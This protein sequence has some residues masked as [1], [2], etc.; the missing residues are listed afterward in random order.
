[1]RRHLAPALG[2]I[3]AANIV[4]TAGLAVGLEAGLLVL[5][6]GDPGEISWGAEIAQALASKSINNG[7]VWL[8]WLVP[9]GAALSLSVVGFAL[10][11]VALEPRS[12]PRWNRAQ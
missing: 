4:F 5:G 10:I 3:I 6:I 8:R 7:W 12:N 11:G 1:M 2:P 9:A